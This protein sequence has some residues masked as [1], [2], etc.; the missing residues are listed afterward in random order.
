MNT[1]QVSGK[2]RRVLTSETKEEAGRK[3]MFGRFCKNR[4]VNRGRLRWR[5]FGYF[6]DEA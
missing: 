6:G 2:K 1:D 3:M 4:A 5:L